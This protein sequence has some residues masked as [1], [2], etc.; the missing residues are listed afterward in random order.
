MVAQIFAL[1]AR[2][3]PDVKRSGWQVLYEY[4]ARKD[5]GADWAFMN[6]GFVNL[7]PQ[8]EPLVLHSSDESDRFG[9]QLYHHVADAIDL[10]G[11][12]V[13]EVGCGRGGG[14]SFIR[15]YLQ[16]RS[17]VGVDLSGRAI[18]LCNL[19]HAGPG[20]AFL[21]GDAESLPLE[22]GTFDVVVNVESS[23]CYGSVPRFLSEV[24]RV[25]RPGGFALFADLRPTDEI[26]RLREHLQ[27]STLQVL[28]EETITPGVLAALDRD[29]ERKRALVR[30]KAPWLIRGQIQEFAGL[31]GSSV[32]ED[33]RRGRAEYLRFVL[34]KA[35]D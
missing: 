16:P 20:L 24:R 17:V 28:K 21:R 14:C 6:Y 31:P 9:I 1:V 26:A 4:L 25:L 29:S 10:R 15:R 18:S 23:H 2:L 34:R 27:A 5:R 7:D 35:A 13:L 22:D 11:L 30:R 33:F 19:H 12:D 32:Y 8:A 3:S